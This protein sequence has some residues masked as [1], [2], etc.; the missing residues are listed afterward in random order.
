M[1]LGLKESAL[2]PPPS[3]DGGFNLQEVLPQYSQPW[4]P[5]PGGARPCPK[6]SEMGGRRRVGNDGLEDCE[7]WLDEE[8]WEEDVDSGLMRGIQ[9]SHRLLIILK[10]PNLIAPVV[11]TELKIFGP[12]EII[13]RAID[14]GNFQGTPRLPI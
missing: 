8:N 1:C 3:E 10:R 11:S 7:E 5:L 2:S 12:V 13:L 14:Y 4:H 9:P 6:P